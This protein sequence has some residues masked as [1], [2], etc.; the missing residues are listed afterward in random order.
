MDKAVQI[1]TAAGCDTVNNML[2]P[3]GRELFTR[4]PKCNT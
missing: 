3:L 1:N 2:K 4:E